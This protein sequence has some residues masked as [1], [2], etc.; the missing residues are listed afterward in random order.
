MDHPSSFGH[1]RSS[2]F[3]QP[4]VV[5]FEP[6]AGGLDDDRL[7]ARRVPFKLEIQPHAPAHQLPIG[8][9]TPHG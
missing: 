5:E 1:P 2:T 6:G 3:S 8:K 4:D 9:V 7:P